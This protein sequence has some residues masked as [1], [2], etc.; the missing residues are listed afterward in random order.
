MKRGVE[1]VVVG[2]GGGMGGG[3]GG[4]MG[5]GKALTRGCVLAKEK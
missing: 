1:V 2:T 4:G 3:K 5:G